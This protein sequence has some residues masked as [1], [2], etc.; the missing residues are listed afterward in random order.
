MLSP[1]IGGVAIRHPGQVPR[2]VRRSFSED[3]S[4]TRAGIQKDLIFTDFPRS[5]VSP[6]P[7]S[8]TGQAPYRVGSRLAGLARNDGFV[9]FSHSLSKPSLFSS[10]II[11]WTM[12]NKKRLHIFEGRLIIFSYSGIH[13]WPGGGFSFFRKEEEYVEI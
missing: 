4:G 2:P 7:L 6:N 5:R 8:N 13:N 11:F 9:E 3:G 1:F 12:F 10:K